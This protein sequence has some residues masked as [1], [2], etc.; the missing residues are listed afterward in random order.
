M[1]VLWFEVTTP[2][3]Y[4]DNGIVYGG[5]QDSLER[6]VRTCSD[7]ELTISF[8][9]DRNNTGR[10]KDGNV[11]YIPMNLNYSLKDKIWNKFTN[12]K[13]ISCIEGE[14][15]KVVELVQPDLIQVFGTE[16]SFGRI[17]R[18]TTIPVV[19][20]IMG[21]LIPY[22]NAQ[23]PPFFS[24]KDLCKAYDILKPKQFLDDF[25]NHIKEKGCEKREME[26]W[27]H[28]KY[29]MGRTEW[30]CALS[31]ILHPGR[32]YFHVD[33]ALRNSFLSGADQWNGYDN[34]RIILIST[35]CSTFW[36][37]PDMLLKVAHILTDLNVDFEW[38]V[39]GYMSPVLKKA[40]ERKLQTTFEKNHVHFLGFTK[41]EDLTDILCHSTLYV[42]TAYVE[43]SP[44]SICEA[45]C[46]GLPI[47]STN[48]GGISSLVE[49][50]KQGVLVPANDPWQMA[51]AI[52]EL[53][54][55]R[56]KMLSFSKNNMTCAFKRHDD[57]KIKIELLNCYRTILNIK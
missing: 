34:K 53:A 9:G 2:Q 1:K 48:V 8:I 31:G 35:G 11:D 40:V 39:A 52:I 57:E 19:V 13:E 56:E 22:M 6:I 50:G 18:F 45:Q 12:T 29:Y 24:Y 30:D 21:S 37:G 16:W 26:I 51:Y 15:Q 36:K 14:M 41:P 4:K 23:Y 27:K 38:K 17:A 25:L 46:L 28:V 33:E 49:N 47:V 3:R 20:H 10:K 44:N 42:H 54:S 7:V 5:W 32:K 43:N 55:N